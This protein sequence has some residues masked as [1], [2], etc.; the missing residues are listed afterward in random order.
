M[1]GTSYEHSLEVE[2]IARELI[3]VHHRHLVEANFAFLIRRSKCWTVKRKTCWG[4]AEKVS[5]KTKFL[6]DKGDEAGIDFII[7]M[8][9]EI[10][11]HMNEKQRKAWTDHLLCHC[12]RG[13]DDKAGN[14]T[15]FSDSHTVEDFAAVIRR[16]GL[17]SE[18]IKA[19]LRAMEDS[20]VRQ[21]EMFSEPSEEA[22]E[23]GQEDL[24][25]NAE[26]NGSESDYPEEPRQ[27]Q[28]AVAA[29]KT[30]QPAGQPMF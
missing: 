27:N 19:M 24:D 28:V 2:K 18:D 17:Y 20:K 16:H 1:A 7:T 4:T 10:W 15:W 11:A 26:S 13:D 5:S 30:E 6:T 21:T 9:G 23:N 8:N 14:P 3:Q 12:G 25:D 29:G 22:E